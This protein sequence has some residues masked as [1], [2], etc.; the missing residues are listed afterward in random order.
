MNLAS[1]VWCHR[2]GRLIS[3]L[4]KIVALPTSSSNKMEL[5]ASNQ[6]NGT[7][8]ALQIQ[9]LVA[10]VDELSRHNQELRQRVLREGSRTPPRRQDQRHNEDERSAEGSNGKKSIKRITQP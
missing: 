6:P 5:D 9:T 10:N 1:S 7:Q 2:W 3:F 4:Q 8:M